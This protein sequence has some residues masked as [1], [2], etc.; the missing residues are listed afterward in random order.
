MVL[1]ASRPASRLTAVVEVVGSCEA[2]D[3]AFGGTITVR[4]F[5]SDGVDGDEV[6]EPKERTARS[7]A[8]GCRRG[9]QR[10]DHWWS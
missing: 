9:T 5:R 2:R 4:I 10:R 1:R 7:E 8:Q 6:L 3:G